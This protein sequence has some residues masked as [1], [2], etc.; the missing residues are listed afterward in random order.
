MSH[1]CLIALVV[2]SSAAYEQPV[3]ANPP[4]EPD[5]SGAGFAE[6]ILKQQAQAAIEEATIR[7]ID[8]EAFE[9][10]RRFETGET[11][12]DPGPGPN[13]RVQFVYGASATRIFCIVQSFCDIE[14]EPDEQVKR[15]LLSNKTQFAV[16][17]ALADQ[18]SHI[19]IQPKMVGVTTSLLIYTD[20]RVYDLEVIATDDAA[21][22]M[23]KVGFVYPKSDFE[24]WSSARETEGHLPAASNEREYQLEADLDDMHFH[25][26]I[27]KE[28][29]WRVRRRITWM[30]E[31]VYDDGER[32]YIDLPASI[33]VGERPILLTRYLDG[34]TAIVNYTPKGRHIIVGGLIEEAILIKGIG[35]WNQERVR[36]RRQ[37]GE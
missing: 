5:V 19:V 17:S 2:A 16:D 13:G 11:G 6:A 20:R 23:P 7:R 36:I 3:T 18:R 14:L 35:W 12:A 24:N 37:K 31:R 33:L 32:T 10:A 1:R 34:T 28:G 4:E 27:R 15:G 29:R 22:H 9:H 30:P 8:K 26:T 25:Y 21:K